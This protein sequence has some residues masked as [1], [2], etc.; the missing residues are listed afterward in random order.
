MCKFIFLLF[1]YLLFFDGLTAKRPNVLFILV[2]DMGARD[3]S[4]EGSTFYESPNIDRIANEGMKF[5]RGYA[6][7]HVC[8]PSRASILT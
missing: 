1:S 3:L 6:T 4:N 8:S 5:T 2:D 7:C